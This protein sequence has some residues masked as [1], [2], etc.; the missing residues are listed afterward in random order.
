[1]INAYLIK[2][3]KNK[4]LDLT[5]LNESILFHCQN[6][7]ISLLSY[8]H[9]IKILRND[10]KIDEVKIDF[11]SKPRLI[12]SSYQFNISHCKNYILIGI[13]DEELGVDIEEKSRVISD[14]LIDRTLSIEEKRLVNNSIDFLR[15]WVKKEA[16]LKYLGTGINRRLNSVD[17]TKLNNAKLYE[18]ENV[19]F[20]VYSH[21]LGDEVN[22][23]EIY[24]ED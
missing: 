16:Y 15:C 22:V 7:E 17:S 21:L 6:N 18:D 10:F 12:N 5:C 23:K 14:N 13:S 1:M 2:I 4:R 3:N 19:I 8:H 11:S 20:C 9:L 24:E